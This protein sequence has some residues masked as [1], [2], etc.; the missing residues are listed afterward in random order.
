MP[1]WCENRVRVTGEF[2]EL[3]RF[4]GFVKDDKL[5][6]SFQKIT[7]MDEKLLDSEEW[8]EWRKEHWGTKWEIGDINFEDSSSQGEIEYNFLTAWAPPVPIFNKLRDEFPELDIS[9]QYDEP[10]MG[11]AGNL[12]YE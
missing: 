4:I 10:G 3:K 5:M 6:F 1:N 11:F 2:D 12:A 8:Y 7:P 9:W